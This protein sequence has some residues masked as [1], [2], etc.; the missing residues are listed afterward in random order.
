[1]ICRKLYLLRMDL[2][3]GDL[4]AEQNW[5]GKVSEKSIG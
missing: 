2:A 4:G 1:M 3:E 5:E